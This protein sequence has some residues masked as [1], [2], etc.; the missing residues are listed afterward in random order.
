M[1]YGFSTDVDYSAQY[2]HCDIVQDATMTNFPV[3]PED[4]EDEFQGCSIKAVALGLSVSKEE[5]ESKC[6]NCNQHSLFVGELK[7]ISV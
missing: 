2:S 7:G 3:D 6:R 1:G 4:P 5:C